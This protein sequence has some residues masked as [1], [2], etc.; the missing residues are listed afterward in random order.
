MSQRSALT[1]AAIATAEVSEPPRPRVVMRLD[2][3]LMPWNPAMTATSLRSLKRL[4]ISVPSMPSIRA[5]AWASLV[6]IG[7]CQPCQERAWMPMPWSTMASR[8]DVT[9]SPEAT[10]ASYSRASCIGEASVHQATSSLVLPDIAETTTATSWPASTSRFTWRA[11]LRIRSMLAT[12]VPPN[13]ITRRLMTTRA[14]PHK[15]KYGDP[16]WTGACDTDRAYTEGRGRGQAGSCAGQSGQWVIRGH[17]ALYRRD[18]ATGRTGAVFDQCAL[19]LLFS[20]DP[21]LDRGA[22]PV[23]SVPANHRRGARP[24]LSRR[25]RAG[26]SG[27]AVLDREGLVPSLYHRDRRDQFAGRAQDRLH[28]APHL[29]DGAG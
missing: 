18:P 15:D 21:G 2:P 16:R 23:R 9:C 29:R 17:G 12:D 14:F 24:A 7:I 13:F 8:P 1:A 27:G 11:T 20:G 5:E 28:Q 26:G 3:G 6:L 4:M 19:D 10:T 25:V 22:G